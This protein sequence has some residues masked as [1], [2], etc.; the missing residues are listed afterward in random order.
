MSTRGKGGRPTKLTEPVVSE[1]CKHISVGTPIKTSCRAAGVSYTSYNYWL[2]QGEL[3]TEIGV[4]T[5]FS[6]FLDRIKKS[7]AEA[8]SAHVQVI[9]NSAIKDKNWLAAA[10]WL[11][12]KYPELFGKRTVEPPVEN[13]ILIQLATIGKELQDSDTTVTP[14]TPLL[15]LTGGDT[16]EVPLTNPKSKRESD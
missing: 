15:E 16:R 11:E 2:K 5:P 9:H 3:D 6:E 10:W 7:E 13:K 14:V 1:I 8:V 12:R 4:I